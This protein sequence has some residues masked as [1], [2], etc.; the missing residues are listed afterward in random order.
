MG[1]QSIFLG[2]F[3][4]KSGKF[5]LNVYLAIPVVVASVYTYLFGSSILENAH[6]SFIR[7]KAK[8]VVTLINVNGGGGTGFLVKGKSGKRYILTNNHI[9]DSAEDKPLLAI[10]KKD[11]YMVS[12][13]SRYAKNDLCVVQAP[14][15]ATDN[16]SLAKTVSM[17]E[18]VYSIGHPLLE[19][20]TISQGELSSLVKIEIVVGTNMTPENCKGETYRL[21]DLSSNIMAG[22]FGVLN[23][24]VRSLMSNGSTVNI[25][26]GNSGSPTV[27]IYGNVVGV[28]FAAVE[29]GVHSYHVPLIDVKD[30][31]ATL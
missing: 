30:F 18:R 24:C 4:K 26:P 6:L 29:S 8:N 11:K 20:I 13:I 2:G 10:Y 17:S 31:L 12:V 25:L 28:V 23:I 5:K 1:T 9:C 7:S 14:E 16:L 15:S 21:E 27:N 3:L 19:P 22:I